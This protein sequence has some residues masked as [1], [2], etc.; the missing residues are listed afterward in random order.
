MSPLVLYG[1]SARSTRGRTRAG[2]RGRAQS[3]EADV[4]VLER[5]LQDSLVV[6]DV[7]TGRCVASRRLAVLGGPH[8]SG[9][10]A[11]R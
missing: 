10:L 3:A 4:R 5:W 6:E 8:H 9:P 7:L 2:R 1:V 11:A